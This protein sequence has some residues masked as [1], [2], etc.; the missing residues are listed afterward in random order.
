MSVALALALLLSATGRVAA[1]G[2]FRTSLTATISRLPSDTVASAP[3]SLRCRRISLHW[4]ELAGARRYVV[5]ASSTGGEP[6]VALPNRNACGSAAPEGSTGLSDVQPSAGT[7]DRTEKVHYKVVAL[8]GDGPDE[9]ALDT[10]TVV[11]V[12]LR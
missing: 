7:P 4:R 10:T 5:Y 11:T 2:T 9:R 3:D 1:Q 8:A 6:W 12:E